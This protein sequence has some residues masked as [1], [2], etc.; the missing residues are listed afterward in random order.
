M[1]DKRDLPEG[2]IDAD[3]PG[4]YESGE[5][6]DGQTRE[7]SAKAAGSAQLTESGSPAR[8]GAAPADPV[9]GS[10]AGQGADPDLAVSEED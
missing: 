5:V 9:E 4:G 8:G 1:S 6:A 7:S 3:P 10:A 2:V